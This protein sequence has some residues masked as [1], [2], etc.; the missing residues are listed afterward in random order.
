MK[1]MSGFD[2]FEKMTN[3]N[4]KF[5]DEAAEMPSPELA[6]A[7]TS[8]WE[9]FS[10]FMNSGWGVAMLCALVAIAVT[11]GIL[12]A[13]RAAG[14]VTTLPGAGPTH[15]TFAFDYVIEPAQDKFYHGDSFTIRTEVKNLSIPFTVTGSSQAFSA[16]AWLVPHGSE[17]VFAAEGRIN[18]LFAYTEDYVVQTIDQG[19]VGKHSGLITIPEDAFL[20][21]YDL[22]L[23][24]KDEYQ[25]FEKV[26]TVEP[27]PW[28]PDNIDFSII[29]E[30]PEREEYAP[31]ETVT[32]DF[33][34]KGFEPTIYSGIETGV[35]LERGY[36]VSAVLT[37]HGQSTDD[38]S[39]IVGNV[40]WDTVAN[41]AVSSLTW[42]YYTATFIIPDG[43]EPGAY[44]LYLCYVSKREDDDTA[45]E[46]IFENVIAITDPHLLLAFSY[47]IEPASGPYYPGD[48]IKITT[49]ITNKG[50]P[51]TIT[52]SS[53]AF[54]AEAK[55]THHYK[56][57]E[58][59]GQFAYD[60]DRVTQTIESGQTG[61]HVGWFKI[62]EDARPGYYD[63][64]LFYGDRVSHA[65]SEL[66]I[67]PPMTEEEALSIAHD[68]MTQR[69]L[70][71]SLDR[72]TPNASLSIYG[73]VYNVNYT[74]MLY[75]IPTSYQFTMTVTFDGTLED[76]QHCVWDDSAYYAVYTDAE[77][78]AAV[79]KLNVE[80]RKT[81]SEQDI[82]N[83]R[84]LCFDTREDGLYLKSE[85]IVECNHEDGEECLLGHH[86]YM[87]EE[88]V[89]KSK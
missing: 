58:I 59:I 88:K 31:G 76:Y 46:K 60:S 2:I 27:E 5:I 41:A 9:R 20:G 43:A 68:Y 71:V 3:V 8:R 87:F 25:V 6:V 86:H 67:E 19:E 83:K 89:I 78:A 51:F 32:L 75:G 52:G 23:A 73:E 82:P 14:P 36:K 29:Q 57:T 12:A 1:A 24:Y 18:G 49:Y 61:I 63:I 11:V 53:Q 79:E 44:D 80:I 81:V 35:P 34:V 64:D 22:V 47:E 48:T 74:Y 56:K 33:A 21:A 50:D 17:D 16:D 55:L 4:D 65:F 69:N 39:A 13:G 45:R 40:V 72:L 15:P 77:V 26:V 85:I 7:K 28:I 54:S 37:P 38:A 10:H 84:L 66:F 62:P 30:A 42:A 70:P